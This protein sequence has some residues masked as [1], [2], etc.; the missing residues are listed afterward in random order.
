MTDLSDRPEQ[1]PDYGVQL[2]WPFDRGPSLVGTVVL[3]PGERYERSMVVTRV[4]SEIA[5]RGSRDPEQR[6]STLL[7][8]VLISKVTNEVTYSTATVQVLIE[9][10]PDADRLQIAAR[11]RNDAANA[12]AKAEVVEAAVKAAP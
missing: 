11:Y 5:M 4:S 2:Y 7:R 12:T 10:L 3:V 8:G 1:H 9:D 6:P